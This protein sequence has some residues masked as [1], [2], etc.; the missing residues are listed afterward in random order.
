MVAAPESMEVNPKPKYWLPAQAEADALIDDPDGPE[1]V[2][3]SGGMGAGKTHWL[4]CQL[5]S[6]HIRN[7]QSVM[8]RG[9]HPDE[10]K[11]IVVSPTLGLLKKIVVP[12]MI[13]VLQEAGLREGRDF[14]I[15][16]TDGILRYTFGGYLYFF[17]ADCPERI[18]GVD[19]CYGGIDEPGTARDG[20]ALGRLKQR[21]RGPGRLRKIAMSGTP[22]D[23]VARQWFYDFIASPEAQEQYGERGS[24]RRRVIFA[25]TRENSFLDDLRGYV[26]GIADVFTKQQQEAYL[27]GRFVAFNLGR[28]Y[29]GFIDRDV[30]LGGHTIPDKHEML[31]RPKR[32]SPL[33]ISLDFNVDPMCGIV[34]WAFGQDGW[35]VADEIRIPK[36]H[37]SEGETPISR[38]CDELVRRWLKPGADDG[39]NGPLWVHGDA[40]E[41]KQTVNASMT[42][43]QI[44]HNCLRHI[45]Q[46]QGWDYVVNVWRSNPLE[47]DRVNTVN[48]AFQKRRLFVAHQCVHLRKDLNLVGFKEGTYQIDKTD[49]ALTHLSDALGYGVVQ[50]GG[51]VS[52]RIDSKMPAVVA[53]KRPNLAEIYDW[54]T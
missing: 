1:W 25:D 38:W 15:N 31:N 2:L 28:V 33:L 42:G 5:F 27:S 53:P 44:V 49:S 10:V 50:K 6:L 13:S 21:M 46:K 7:L 43:W 37:L 54:G 16:R 32:G 4:C 45:I 12:K 40:T 22:E 11:G 35:V 24:N 29:S 17:S 23:I 41:S 26:E 18:I 47:K 19:A 51:Y 30:D 48:N 34:G 39:W 52:T 9:I 20:E 36:G 14:K 8:E 3:L